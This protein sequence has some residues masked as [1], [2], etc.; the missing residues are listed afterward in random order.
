MSYAS[1]KP[2]PRRRRTAGTSS[3][4]LALV[5][6]AFLMLLLGTMDIA[7]Y[8]FTMQSVGY[9]VDRAVREGVLNS[10]Y[11]MGA[12]GGP[13]PLVSS[14]TLHF[15]TPPFMDPGTTMCVI[16]TG[17]TGGGTLVTVTVTSPFVSFTPGLSALT[18]TTQ[19]TETLQMT[20]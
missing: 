1:S 13:C 12:Q 5:L 10:S 18:S 2:R 11:A 14:Q 20:Y 8:L 9:L 15:A 7:R 19:L 3:L 17:N 6:V 4:E 16:Q